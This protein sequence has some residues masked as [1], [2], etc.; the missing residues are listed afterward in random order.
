MI[1]EK[2]KN[3]IVKLSCWN[4]E[5]YKMGLPNPIFSKNNCFKR[6]INCRYNIHFCDIKTIQILPQYKCVYHKPNISWLNNIIDKIHSFIIRKFHTLISCIQ[7]TF[8]TWIYKKMKILC[9]I[10]SFICFYFIRQHIYSCV[11]C[12]FNTWYLC[13]K[14]TNIWMKFFCMIFIIN[15]LNAKLVMWA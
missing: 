14:C 7:N 5:I 11:K 8:N 4:F 6:F 2:I 1:F 13:V 9:D 3:K 12:V 10:L 15:S